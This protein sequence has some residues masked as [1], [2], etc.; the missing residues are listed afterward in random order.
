M[1]HDY[2]TLLFIL[3]QQPMA[4]GVSDIGLKKNQRQ[5]IIRAGSRHITVG[6]TGQDEHTI[7]IA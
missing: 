2:Y 6:S 1:T 5:R 7:H 4:V 3:I